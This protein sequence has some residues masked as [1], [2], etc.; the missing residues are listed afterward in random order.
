M[1]SLVTCIYV[2]ASLQLYRIYVNRVH[3]N[4]ISIFDNTSSVTV[5]QFKKVNQDC[6]KKPDGFYIL[7]RIRHGSL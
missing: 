6:F 2:A 7:L 5:T 3:C 1:H 4:I